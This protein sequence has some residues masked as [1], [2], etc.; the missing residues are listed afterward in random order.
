MAL[1]AQTCSQIG[2]DLPNSKPIIPPL[3]K[4][5][6]KDLNKP[7]TP[8]YIDVKGLGSSPPSK[9]K[10][11]F[12]ASPASDKSSPKTPSSHIS[13]KSPREDV[14]PNGPKSSSESVKSSSSDS[15]SRSS[16][17]SAQSSSLST[18]T[19]SL[20]AL[21]LAGKLPYPFPHPGYFGDAEALKNMPLGTF[22]PAAPGFGLYA[23]ALARQ[24]AGEAMASSHLASNLSSHPSALALRA[25]AGVFPPGLGH[26]ANYSKMKPPGSADSIVP[27]PLCRDP[28]CNGCSSN[29][30]HTPLVGG[31]PPGCTQCENSKSPIGSLSSARP[32]VCNWVA[33]D[34]YCGKCFTTSDELLQHLRTHTNLSTSDS[35][36]AVS[37]L[38]SMLNPYSLL[39]SPLAGY[40]YPP[41]LGSSPLAASRYHPY[42]KPPGVPLPSPL[43]L[44]PSSTLPSHPLAAYYSP[45]SLFGSRPGSLHH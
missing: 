39:P 13:P 45:Y 44:S 17:S 18:S 9:E 16:V 32:Y 38:N 33:G 24:M 21:S 42:A 15:L 22:N 23:E 1:L 40:R 3:E 29:S 2:A 14:I 4:P 30:H 37:M 8:S 5:K 25:A 43:S 6:N 36:S 41:A 20:S 27:P 11:D 26:L 10:D 35:A 28:Y 7:R 34:N 31:C 12:V 19:P